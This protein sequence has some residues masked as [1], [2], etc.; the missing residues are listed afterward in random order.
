MRKSNLEPLT[1]LA[2]ILIFLLARVKSIT[3]M[4]QESLIGACPVMVDLLI[5][6]PLLLKAS[7]REMRHLDVV[8]IIIKDVD[9]DR[10]EFYLTTQK[11]FVYEVDEGK[12]PS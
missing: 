8:G 6:I 4:T 9:R 2:A 11:S 5:A 10:Y 7:A 12:S 3:R 1:W